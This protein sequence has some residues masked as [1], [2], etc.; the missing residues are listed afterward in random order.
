MISPEHVASAVAYA[1]SRLADVTL[2]NITLSS[3]TGNL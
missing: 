3:L 1:L 2:E